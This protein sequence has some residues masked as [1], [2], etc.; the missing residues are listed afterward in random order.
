[1]DLDTKQR[2]E[3]A[4][5]IIEAALDKVEKTTGL[6]V[7]DIGVLRNVNGRVQVIILLWRGKEAKAKEE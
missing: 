3:V 6:E 2:I 1:M 4:E 5:E 7:K